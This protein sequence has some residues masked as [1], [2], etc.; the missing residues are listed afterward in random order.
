METAALFALIVD[1]TVIGLSLITL[2][3]MLIK[4]NK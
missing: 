2:F 3:A 1:A 4:R